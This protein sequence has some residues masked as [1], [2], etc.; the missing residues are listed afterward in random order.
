MRRSSPRGLALLAIVTGAAGC[1]GDGASIDPTF[2]AVVEHVLEP[3]CTF[4]SCHASPTIAATLNLTAERACDALVNQPSCLFPDR[5][6]VIPGR[7]DDSFFFHKIDGQGLGQTPT[8][9]CA[10]TN[11][12]MPFGGAQLPDDERALV[13]DWIAAGA[14][15]TPNPDLPPGDLPP[16]LASIT[17]DRTT[18]L[19]GETIAIT[20]ALDKPAP[21]GGL[22]I[23][24]ATSSDAIS[25]PVQ[26]VIPGA[27]AS[28]RFEAYALRPTS[29]FTLRAAMGQASKEIVLRVGGLEVSEVMADPIGIDD[30][31]QW[32]KL[33]NRSSLPIDLSGYDLRA[34]ALDYSLVAVPLAGTIPAGGCAVI[35][36]PTRSSINGTPNY[37]QAVNFTPDLPHPRTGAAGYALVDRGAA[38]VGG[39]AAPMD[40]MIV[41]AMNTRLLNPDA[42]IASPY[43]ATPAPGTSALRTGPITCVQTTMQPNT[44]Q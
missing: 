22:A 16:A 31:S 30:G 33:H 4:S 12:L 21:E 39:V 28:A 17:T 10:P 32:I 13:H 2:E 19:A 35:G 14:A 1:T 42:V 41:G 23:A 34:G 15:C 36:G 5:M 20:V 9:S 3:R 38:P 8:G 24:L 7:P 26:V 29:R 25:A 37:A 27:S 43:C 18:P 11:L 44:C 40:A 6:R